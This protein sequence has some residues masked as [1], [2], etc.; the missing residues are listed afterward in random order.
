M[1][2]HNRLFEESQNF[3]TTQGFLAYY[4]PHILN[5][6]GVYVPPTSFVTGLAMKRYRDDIAGFRLPPAGSKYALAGARGVQVPIT[7]GM[8]NVSNPYGLNALRQLPG[9]S[10]TDPDTGITY[11]PVFVWGA[12][13]RIMPGNAEQA[14]YKFVNTR[15]IMNVIYGTLRNALDNQIFNII[16]GRAVTFN[17]IRTPVSNTLY[18][19]FYVPGALF[20]ASAADAFDVVVD[21][22]N[23]P[24]ASLENGLVNVQVFVVPVPT[25]ERIEIDLLRVSIGGIADAKTNLGLG[26]V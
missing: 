2:S 8:Q 14:L 12:R 24:A 4:A 3:S 23:N 19:N 9:Y 6:V 16:D 1:D 5:D 17:Q 18:S 22:R 25:L 21:D 7:T 15:V 10:N 26:D 11:G 13:T 20:G